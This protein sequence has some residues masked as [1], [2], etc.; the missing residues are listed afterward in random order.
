MQDCELFRSRVNQLLSTLRPAGPVA[1][2]PI[3]GSNDVE[4]VASGCCTREIDGAATFA[5]VQRPKIGNDIPPHPP[6][7]QTALLFGNQCHFSLPKLLNPEPS[8]AK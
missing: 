7:I 6:I 4:Q 1:W 5:F 3:A 2:G 8:R